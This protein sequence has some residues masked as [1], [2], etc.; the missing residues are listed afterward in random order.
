MVI[1]DILYLFIV[2]KLK[3]TD[4]L[5]STI[6]KIGCYELISK[7]GLVLSIGLTYRFR[8]MTYVLKTSVGKS[9]MDTIKTTFPKITNF[10]THHSKSFANWIA[11]NKYTKRI[12]ET[13]QLKSKRFGESLI[14]GFILSHMFTPLYVK[15]ALQCGKTKIDK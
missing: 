5:K 9:S 13:L 3:M 2:L 10:V 15:L 4:T 6:K 7:T 1:R 14:E 11:T 8:P 12:P